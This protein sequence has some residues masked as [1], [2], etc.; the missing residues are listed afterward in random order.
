MEQIGYV[1][2]VDNVY[3]AVISIYAGRKG[4]ATKGK[5]PEGRVA[6]EE[7][8]NLAMSSFKDLVK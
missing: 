1:D 5:E 2:N 3:Q 7:G 8:I 6:F 4:W